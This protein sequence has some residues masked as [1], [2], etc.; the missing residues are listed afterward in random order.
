MKK[1]KVNTAEEDRDCLNLSVSGFRYQILVIRGI[2]GRQFRKPIKNKQT[3]QK[4]TLEAMSTNITAGPSEHSSPTLP[5]ITERVWQPA[6]GL[7]GATL[8]RTL[9]EEHQS[10]CSRILVTQL[11]I[12]EIT[13]GN[14]DRE[15][16]CP[17]VSKSE[18]KYYNFEI[19]VNVTSTGW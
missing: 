10:I 15:G 17:S 12:P 2:K 16:R 11:D 19:N 1:D 9:K 7:R 14:F 6:H 18:A 13:R 5:G 3:K 8:G 4:K